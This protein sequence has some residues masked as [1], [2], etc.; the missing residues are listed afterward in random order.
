MHPSLYI[1]GHKFSSYQTFHYLGFIIFSVYLAYVLLKYERLSW[2]K[3]FLYVFL[4]H[5]ALFWGGA[6]IPF[7]YQASAQNIW[8][9]KQFE[10]SGNFIQTWVGK[11]QDPLNITSGLAIDESGNIWVVD[12]GNNRILKFNLPTN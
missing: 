10:K 8:G 6:I 2:P 9:W 3:I 7:I 1:L 12:S 11:M 5:I 4:M